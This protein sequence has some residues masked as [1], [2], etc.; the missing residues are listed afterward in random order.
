MGTLS[1]SQNFTHNVHVVKGWTGLHDLIYTAA[2]KTG[3]SFD[4][5]ALISLDVTLGSDS[6]P[7]FIAGCSDSAMPMFA[8]N[9]SDDFGANSD[10]GNISG[11]FVNAIVGEG[12]Y[13]IFTTE[14]SSGTY[15][16]NT[17]LCP[18]LSS[19]VGQVAQAPTNYNDRAI[20]GQVSKGVTATQD[21]TSVLYF[22]TK[23]IPA[24]KTT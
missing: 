1:P 13:E 21:G 22:W 14:Y 16:P 24:V 11:G 7:R 8:L 23:A 6:L 12:S 4:K 3:E 2:V 20:V 5:G 19:W 10:V 18:G 15:N 9:G 17:F